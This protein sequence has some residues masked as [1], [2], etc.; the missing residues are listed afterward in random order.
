[1]ILNIG[2]LTFSSKHT[3]S[4]VE[5]QL[6]AL[7]NLWLVSAL[8]IQCGHA[9]S[10]IDQR[11]A[12]AGPFLFFLERRIIHWEQSVSVCRSLCDLLMH[13]AILTLM[14]IWWPRRH[15]YCSLVSKYYS[16]IK[17]QLRKLKY[18]FSINK[19][20]SVGWWK[21]ISCKR[22]IYVFRPLDSPQ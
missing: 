17:W 16:V 19:T 14:L 21:M 18:G 5:S 9:L 2:P 7:K 8:R 11:S 4:H 15:V 6:R 1:M 10:L 3:E 22:I 12:Y 20:L 13:L